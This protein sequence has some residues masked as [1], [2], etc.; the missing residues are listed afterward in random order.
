MTENPTLANS[1]IQIRIRI[2]ELEVGKIYNINP[3][4]K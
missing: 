4:K 2:N 3:E 1:P